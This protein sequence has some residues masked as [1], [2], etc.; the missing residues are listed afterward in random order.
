MIGLGVNKQ[1]DLQSL[2]TEVGRQIARAQGWMDKRRIVQVWFIVFFGIAAVAGVLSFS[3][4]MRNWFRRFTLVFIGFFFL[5]SLIVIRA[6]SFHHFYEIIQYRFLGAK[7][8]WA[9]ELTGI[10]LIVLA[11]C[12]EIFQRRRIRSRV[13]SHKRGF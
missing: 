7:M 1:V 10:Y 13:P 11:G 4:I 12:K 3:I 9:L 5:T 2:L 8:N 6:V